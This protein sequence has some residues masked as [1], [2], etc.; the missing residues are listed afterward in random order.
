[1][2][3]TVVGQVLLLPVSLANILSSC[4]PANARDALMPTQTRSPRHQERVHDSGPPEKAT[5]DSDSLEFESSTDLLDAQGVLGNAFAVET[6]HQ[7]SSNGGPG[8]FTTSKPGD[9]AECEADDVSRRVTRGEAV[10]VEAQPTGDLL[11]SWDDVLTGAGEGALAGAGVGGLFGGG[12]GALLG[13]GVGAV[14]GGVAGALSGG[15]ETDVSAVP[16][17]PMRDAARLLAKSDV[18]IE[19]NTAR[20]LASGTIRGFYM[21]DLAQP[22]NVDTLV[23]GYGYD[24]GTYTLYTH[25]ITNTMLLVQKNAE[26]FRPLGRMEIFG[27]RSLS[28]DR[29]KTLLIHESNHALSPDPTTP[30]ERYKSE[31]RAYW[32]AE[33]AVVEDLDSRASQIKAHILADYPIISAPYNSDAAVKTAIDAHTRPEGNLTN[34]APGAPGTSPAAPGASASPA[35]GAGGSPTPG[36]GGSP[37]AGAGGSSASGASAQHAS[38]SPASSGAPE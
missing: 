20:N 27:K 14:V 11:G 23:T 3:G 18:E 6:F 1:V 12:A 19:K 2:L 33:Y 24:P 31:F 30:I 8:G 38:T 34:Q 16:E 21:E 4:L 25:P 32:V 15:D 35:P 9:S 36:A 37:A 28:V 22:A 17:G 10:E 7:I 29:W 26:G 5:V 13:A